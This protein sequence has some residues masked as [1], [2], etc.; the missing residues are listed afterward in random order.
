MLEYVHNFT[1]IKNCPKL[2]FANMEFQAIL[3]RVGQGGPKSVNRKLPRS[4]SVSKWGW[5]TLPPPPKSEHSLTLLVSESWLLV[6][7]FLTMHS[8]VLE[9]ANKEVQSGSSDPLYMHGFAYYI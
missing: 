7:L 5:G 6:Y 9:C 2:Q 8:V 3:K 1:P 4:V